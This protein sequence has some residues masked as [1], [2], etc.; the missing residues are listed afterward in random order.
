MKV[1]KFNDVPLGSRIRYQDCD[2]I[3]TVLHKEQNTVGG[4]LHG[5]LAEWR[6]DM[7]DLGN[8]GGQSLVSHI[9]IS[10]GGDCPLEVEFLN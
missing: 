4:D 10:E 1:M 9:P 7:G 3:W 2:T 6:K 8:W 5:I